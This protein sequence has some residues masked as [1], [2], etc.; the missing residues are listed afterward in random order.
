M[1][2]TKKLVALCRWSG[3]CSR[4]FAKATLKARPAKLLFVLGAVF[5]FIVSITQSIPVNWKA[6]L[7]T[8]RG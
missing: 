2:K 3:A 1:T 4:E 8:S 7:D 6:S 5:I